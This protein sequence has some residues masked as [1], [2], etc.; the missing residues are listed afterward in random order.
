[1]TGRIELHQ[2]IDGNFRIK[3]VDDLMHTLAVSVDFV[4]EK[5]ALE[6]AFTLREIAGT[7]HI[8]DCTTPQNETLTSGPLSEAHDSTPRRAPTDNRD[9]DGGEDFH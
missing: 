1:M 6:C 2:E 7:A 8:I 3:M 4:S 5:A 9:N